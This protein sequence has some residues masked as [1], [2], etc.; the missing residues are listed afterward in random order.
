MDK[1]YSKYA[2]KTRLKEASLATFSDAELLTILLKPNCLTDTQVAQFHTALVKYEG[3]RALTRLPE[4][5]FC[6]AMGVQG[7]KYKQLQVAKEIAKRISYETLKRTSSLTSPALTRQFLMQALADYDYEIFGLLLLDSQ[8]RVIAFHELIRGTINAAA[9]YPREVV[10]VMLEKSAAVVILVHNH[11]S[12]VSEPSAADK[13]ITQKLIAILK[14][15]DV[16]VLDH[17]VVGDQ[18]ITSFAERGWIL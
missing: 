8:H 16:R 1:L 6:D 5:A 15:I 11:P 4:A 14:M 7:M 17:L 18:E 12:G 2:L 3:L 10:K 13:A 9:V